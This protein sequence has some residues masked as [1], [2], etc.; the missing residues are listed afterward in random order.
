MH[1]HI[2]QTVQQID[3]NA[4]GGFWEVVTEKKGWE[5]LTVSASM[6]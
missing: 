4:V 1:Y 5:G 3:S 2:C 6:A